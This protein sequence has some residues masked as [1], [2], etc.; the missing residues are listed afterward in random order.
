MQQV[1]AATRPGPHIAAI[2]E[3]VDTPGYGFP[4]IRADF[5]KSAERKLAF[6]GHLIAI[7]KGPIGW[8]TYV[9]FEGTSCI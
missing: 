4:D 7:S 1:A 2:P 5:E 6:D 8:D 3:G 9:N